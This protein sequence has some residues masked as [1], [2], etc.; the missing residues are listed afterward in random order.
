[1]QQ[2]QSF[3]S[4]VSI[5][6][7]YV[8]LGKCVRYS[9][10][11]GTQ[12]FLINLLL[13]SEFGLMRY[14]T[15]LVGMASLINE[16]GL[17]TAIV[18]KQQ[19][20]AEEIAGCFTASMIWGLLLYIAV[21]LTAPVTALFFNNSQLVNYLR[22]GS[23]L[24]PV[25]SLCSV[26]RALLQKQMRFG[27]LASVEASA[28]VVSSVLMIS[29]AFKGYGTWSLISGALV[30]EVLSMTLLFFWTRVPGVNFRALLNSGNILGTGIGLVL[31]RIVDYLRFSMPFFYYWEIV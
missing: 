16:M 14:V 2:S 17:T 25:S 20:A 30:Q 26:P 3:R 22:I 9:L 28:A 31:L 8:F 1:M 12:L 29:L 11:Y 6:G 13:P 10:Q 27:T 23:L 18:Q 15:I 24:I 4:Q 19:L 21:F 5:S 7:A